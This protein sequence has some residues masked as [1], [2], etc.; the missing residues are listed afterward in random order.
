M[1]NTGAPVPQYAVWF[2]IAATFVFALP[3]LLFS[4]PLDT[5]VRIALGIAGFVLVVLGG[6]QLG[7]EMRGRRKPP[8]R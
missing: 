8:S 2:F 1:T 4:D 3:T 6:A 7:R 5:W